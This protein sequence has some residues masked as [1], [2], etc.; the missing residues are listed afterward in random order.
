MV[1]L[2]GTETASVVA[3]A[4]AAL[5]SVDGRE[6]HG[7]TRAG[8]KVAFTEAFHSIPYAL[9]GLS[10]S[11]LCWLVNCLCG[12]PPVEYAEYVYSKMT[13]F[14]RRREGTKRRKADKLAVL[15]LD[16]S[17]RSR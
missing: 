9:V 17:A 5:A 1:F 8:R 7:K 10:A 4:A 6:R 3:A 14:C 16:N 2:I 12:W 11:R 13:C 15:F